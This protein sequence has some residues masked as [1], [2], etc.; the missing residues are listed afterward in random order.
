MLKAGKRGLDGS[1]KKVNTATMASD[2][3]LKKVNTATMASNEYLK[4][5]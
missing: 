2:E 1:S 5:G 4:K 3:Y